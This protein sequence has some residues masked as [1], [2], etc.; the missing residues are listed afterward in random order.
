MSSSPVSRLANEMSN[1][2]RFPRPTRP[3]A[4][5]LVLAMLLSVAGL[6]AVG[7]VE[8]SAPSCTAHQ[9]SARIASWQGAAGS[10]IADIR[11]INTSFMAC[12]I[13]NFPKVQLVSSHGVV[14]ING[15][16]ASTTGAFHTLAPLGFLKTEAATSNYCG[17]AF[18]KPVT[19]ALTLPALLGRV[20]AIPVSPTD[21]GGV[22]PC[23]GSPGSAGHISIHSW[24]T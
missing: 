16:A 10:R 9:L 20:V 8:A 19:L 15:S 2:P 18:T 22:P 7:P 24:H 17:P 3:L 23:L 14:M 6:A 5:G 21:A 11:L 12:K 13:R 4:G 1:R